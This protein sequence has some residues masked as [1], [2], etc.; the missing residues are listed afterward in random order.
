MNLRRL[1][2]RQNRDLDLSKEIEFH[3]ETEV[4]QNLARGMSA[5]AARLN[6]RRKF[7]NPT[8]IREEVYLMSGVSL[9]EAIWN[10]ICHSVRTLLNNRAFTAT[11]ILTLALGIGANTAMFT[12][13]RAVLL[14]PLEYP[15]P[16]RL[17]FLS[18]DNP[19][20]NVHNVAFS[21]PRC[22]Q[23]ETSTRSFSVLGCFLRSTENITLSGV[24]EPEALKGARVSANF[25]EVLAD[26]DTPGGPAVA[27]ISAALWKRRFGGNVQSIGRSAT[28]NSIPYTIIGVLPEEFA[29]PSPG[30]DVWVTKPS[31]WSFLLP[32]HWRVVATQF[33]FA[34]LIPGVSLEQARAEMDVMNQHQIAANAKRLDARPG[35][36]IRVVLLKDRIVSNVRP[37]LWMLFGAVGLVLLIACANL[38]SLMLA[39]A[40]SRSKEFAVRAALGAGRGKLMRQLL[41]ESLVLALAGGLAG[42]LLAKVILVAIPHINELPLPRAG[43]IRVDPIVLGFTAV[44]SVATGILFG[45][46]PSLQGSRPDVADVLRESGSAA[47]PGSFWRRGT[48]GISVRGLLVIAQVALSL[49]LLIG[50]ALLIKSFARL[51]TVDP[52]F[53]PTQLL[54]MKI[55]LPPPRYDT[56][57]K[58]VAFFEELERRVAAVPGVKN[59]AITRSIPTVQ[60]VFTNVRVEGQPPVAPNEEPTALLQSVTPDYFRTMRIPVRRGRVFTASDNS[61]GA[62]P[63]V[64]ANESFAR[65]FWPSY[66]DGPSPIGRHVGERADRIG[67]LEIIGIVADVHEGGFSTKPGPEFYVPLAVNAPQLAYLVIRTAADPRQMV[68]AIRQALAAV[69]R[70]QPLADIRMMEEVFDADLRQRRLTMLLLSVFSGVAL[71]LTLVGLYGAIAYS[72]TQRTRELGIRRVLGAEH[73]DIL[74]LV[75]KQ[76]LG[77]TAT[78][79]IIGLGGALAVGRVMGT[80][81]FEVSTTDAGTFVSVAVAFIAV[82]IAASLIPA[83][84]ALRVDPMLALR[85]G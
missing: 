15:D 72:V 14:K 31:E 3:Y 1:L 48:F 20:E 58:R 69:D 11:A 64:I 75:L 84:R 67:S 78:G 19:K 77:L 36:S 10:D 9:L 49:L 44:L 28:I 50:A 13:V 56:V 85:V 38:A 59:A 73:R 62:P 22:E 6:A 18:L 45:M 30:V 21:P 79:L 7:G 34:R 51:R 26:E 71:V 42:V 65:R 4:E 33:A 12:V 5:E 82:A 66:P 8:L 52:G 2:P 23:M 37:M 46:I 63:V 27:M 24:G 16:D 57:Q 40:L 41:V 83:W 39:R 70:D 74:R 43:A 29:F 32:R 61:L 81:L 55:P 53:Q 35:P 47:G 68:P 17:V 76:A 25:L 80:L 60:W 54:T